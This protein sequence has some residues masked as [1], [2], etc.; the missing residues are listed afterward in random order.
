[1]EIGLGLDPRFA[2]SADDQRAIA[3][4][5]AALGYAS[6]WTPAGDTREPFDLCAL[7]HEASGLATGIAV[8]PLS[9]W[10]IDDLASVSRE[11]QDRCDGRFTLGI[12]SGRLLDAPI[13]AMREAIEALRARLPGSRVYLG[14][15]GPQ[16]LRLAGGHYD[17]VALNWCSAPQVRWSRERVA[18]AA[19]GA[20]RDVTAVRIHEYVRV[21]VDEDEPAARM[22]LAKTVLTYALRPN[23]APRKGYRAHFARMGFAAVLEDLD[24]RRAAGAS[25]DEL[26]G[27]LPDTLLREVGYWGGPAGAR[28][29]FGKLAAGLDI[30][31]VRLVPTRRNDADAV[32]LTMEA[33]A[34]RER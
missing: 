17:G 18:A 19:R 1:M 30:A 10:K 23:A 26:A 6:L 20:G 7:W 5:A 13:R 4:E 25:D 24:G 27:A 32:R 9:G 8:A 22:S 3:R 21:C 12:G 2:L 11:T 33:C 29:A 16:M 15:L 34:P 31:V 14:A 28:E